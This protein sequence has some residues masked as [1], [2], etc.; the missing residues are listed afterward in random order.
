MFC[1]LTVTVTAGCY[2]WCAL[3]LSRD[4]DSAF[5]RD[6]DSASL[7]QCITIT[8]FILSDPAPPADFAFVPLEVS[9][10]GPGNRQ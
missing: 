7:A 2:V 10:I 4:N 8:T 3:K 9:D 5:S 1:M 6:N